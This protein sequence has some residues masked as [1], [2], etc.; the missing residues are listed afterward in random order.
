MFGWLAG[1]PGLAK[2]S[3]TSNKALKGL[4]IIKILSQKRALSQTTL[5]LHHNSALSP[6]ILASKKFGLQCQPWT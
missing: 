3:T 6:L 4:N 5:N 1:W 2:S